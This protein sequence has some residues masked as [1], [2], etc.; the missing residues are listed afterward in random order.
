METWL[1][2]ERRRK[3]IRCESKA[4]RWGYAI[5]AVVAGV[6]ADLV[7]VASID[8][9]EVIESDAT[10]ETT[11]ILDSSEESSRWAGMI[12]RPTVYETVALPLSYTGD[13]REI[14]TRAAGG[15]QAAGSLLQPRGGDDHAGGLLRG[16]GELRLRAR[17]LHRMWTTGFMPSIVVAP[18]I[19][20]RR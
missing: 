16:R 17:E 8:E 10:V 11:A 6:V 5:G 3:S 14:G 9:H 19:T 15:L 20:P 4:R 18:S 2:G 13:A 1:P 12:R 7:G